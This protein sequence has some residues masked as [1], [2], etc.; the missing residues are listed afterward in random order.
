MLNSAEHE[1]YLAHKRLNANN[2]WHIL[3]TI[4][5]INTTSESLE[6]RK[7]YIFQHCSFYEQLKFHTQLSLARKKFYNLGPGVCLAVSVLNF[8]L[9][10]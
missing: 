2:C 3:T 6:A 7:V 8:L 9:T 4:S 5:M 1:V 10:G